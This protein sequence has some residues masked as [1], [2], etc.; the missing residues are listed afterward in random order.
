MISFY[1]LMKT[2]TGAGLTDGLYIALNINSLCIH[3]RS[4]KRNVELL[5]QDPLLLL[6][7]VLSVSWLVL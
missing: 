5:Q 3:V 7:A 1:T 4:V 2:N 6:P